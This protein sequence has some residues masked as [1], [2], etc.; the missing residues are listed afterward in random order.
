MAVTARSALR[1][2]CPWLIAAV[3]HLTSDCWAV[4]QAP[5][6]REEEDRRIELQLKL[7]I[8]AAIRQEAL[9]QEALR[10]ELLR[11][12][13]LRRDLGILERRE[14]G[15]DEFDNFA[16][17]PN[18][19]LPQGPPAIPEFITGQFRRL[20]FGS[21]N[22]RSNDTLGPRLNLILETKVRDLH[23]ICGLTD[24]Q[25]QKLALAGQGDIK[26]FLDVIE[27]QFAACRLLDQRGERDFPRELVERALIL[28]AALDSG[29]FND[30]SIFL[31]TLNNSLSARQR[32]DYEI[33][34]NI[35]RLR[36]KVHLRSRGLR[37]IL[38]IRMTDAAFADE[39]LVHFRRLTNLQGLIL[40]YTQ[41]SD[42]GLANLADL[43]RLELLDLGGTGVTGSGL[44]HLQNMQHLL[45]LDLRR[46]RLTDAGLAE[47]HPLTDLQR[48]HLE[49][50]Q[51]TGAGFENLANL[52]N[53]ETLQLT[54]TRFNDAGL[55]HLR[56]FKNLK[57][58]SLEGTKITDEGVR[59]LAGLTRLESLDLRRTA[60]TDAGL[61]HLAGLTRLQSLYLFGTQITDDGVARL[62]RAL[63]ETRVIR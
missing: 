13:L 15:P 11:Q 35:E 31:K 7:A 14:S 60:V 57:E 22:V 44:R 1:W 8:E 26:R 46:T 38:T 25:K 29:P 63:P 43:T 54:Q 33:Y 4:A 53:L 17:E 28:S 5:D 32:S 48:L 18:V 56:H 45:W 59:H 16:D 30:Q 58:L 21:Q 23:L 37:E 19:Q 47:L 6:P 52:T 34:R 36:G 10:R 12:E 51:I 61:V 49:H 40:D 2:V 50:T 41:V 62:N 24:I 3:C 39:G 20:I 55:A 42:D 27:A 9:R